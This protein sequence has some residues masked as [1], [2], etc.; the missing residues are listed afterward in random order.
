MWKNKDIY[1][2][3]LI[4]NIKRS[5][6]KIKNNLLNFSFINIFYLSSNPPSSNYFLFTIV[7]LTHYFTTILLFL[8]PALLCKHLRLQHCHLQNF[9]Q[10]IIRLTNIKLLDHSC[11][12][13]GSFLHILT[14][15]LPNC[16]SFSN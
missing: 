7:S 2:K 11:Y 3:I 14:K 13:Q 6:D 12:L 15:I 9:L 10:N 8:C 16:Q 4:Y 1:V 5:I